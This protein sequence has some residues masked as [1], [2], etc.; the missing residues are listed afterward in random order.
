MY[1]SQLKLLKTWNV[2]FRLKKILSNHG[3]TVCIAPTL[4]QLG[5]AE[6]QGVKTTHLIHFKS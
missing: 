3:E 4:H 2:I 6:F 1:I 5:A